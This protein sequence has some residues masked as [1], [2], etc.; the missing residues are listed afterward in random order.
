[1]LFDSIL[2]V[3]DEIVS[4]STATA[5]SAATSLSALILVILTDVV[6]SCDCHFGYVT[7]I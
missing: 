6:E 2:H 7:K 5:L 4:A 3:S 1:M